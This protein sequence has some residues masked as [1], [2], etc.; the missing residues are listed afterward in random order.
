MLSDYNNKICP[1][2]IIS[3]T[4]SFPIRNTTPT[5]SKVLVDV[6]KTPSSPLY[7]RLVYHGTPS[8]R[9]PLH[10][11]VSSSSLNIVEVLKLTKS[12]KRSKSNLTTIDFDNIDVRDVKYLPP[13]FD[14][15]IF[16]C[17]PRRQREFQGCMAVPCM[18]WIRCV[19]DTLSAQQKQLI[20]RMILDYHLAVFLVLVISSAQMIIVITCITIE[21][22]A[23]TVN[24]WD[25]ILFHFM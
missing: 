14:G 24:R 22:F 4:S 9:P 2:V 18:A 10:P 3:D 11:C 5:P 15:D 25:Q 21:G 8:Q 7:M 23:T 13:S 1:A 17:C 6:D 12:R 20:S 19:M 16:F